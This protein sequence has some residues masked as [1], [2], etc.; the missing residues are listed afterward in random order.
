[1]ALTITRNEKIFEVKGKINASTA[2]YF[3][4]HFAITLNSLDGLAIDINNV[5]EI[6][7][8]GIQAL[9]SIYDKAQSWNKSFNIVGNGSKKI[10]S[11]FDYM[12]AV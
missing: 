3:H 2:S 5:T 1:M 7:S 6:D 9:K 11:E 8:S 10:Y 4:T 12:K